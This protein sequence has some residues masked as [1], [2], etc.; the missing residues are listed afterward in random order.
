VVLA[1][2][3]IT[4][5]AFDGIGNVEEIRVTQGNTLLRETDHEY[6]DERH[7][8]VGIENKANNVLVSSFDYTRRRMGRLCR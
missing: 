7:W 2:P 6:D 4:K 8:L 1:E 3:V 5:Y